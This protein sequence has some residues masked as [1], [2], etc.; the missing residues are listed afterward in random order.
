MESV[1]L[2][3]GYLLPEG[4]TMADIRRMDAEQLA[5]EGIDPKRLGLKEDSGGESD[6][7]Q[8]PDR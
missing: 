8:S 5:S 7:D 6:S 3:A 1:K 2:P 4:T